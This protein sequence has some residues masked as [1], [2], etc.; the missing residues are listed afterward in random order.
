MISLY[1]HMAESGDPQLLSMPKGQK[2][3]PVHCWSN[4]RW[5]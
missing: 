4:A 1:K 2:G 5:R 3:S